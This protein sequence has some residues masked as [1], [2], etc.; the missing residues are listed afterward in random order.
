VTVTIDTNI[1]I[2]ALNFS[3]G[4]PRQLLQMALEGEVRVAI[5]DAILH[6]TL[7]VMREKF[8]AAPEDLKEVEDLISGCTHRVAPTDSLAVI[9]EDPDDDRIL[10]C[11][12]ASGSE[13]IV[14]GDKD[15][16]RLGEY[17]GIRIIRVSEFLE[18][19]GRQG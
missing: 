9:K 19:Y 3:K 12:V 18:K 2:S 13:V 7:R 8:H 1:Y 4:K 5:S 11:A 17:A 6:E 16:L 15:L 10:E 14:S